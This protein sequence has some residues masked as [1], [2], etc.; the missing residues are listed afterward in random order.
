[1][2]TSQSKLEVVD[3]IT[4]S[5]TIARRVGLTI[6]DI[7]KIVDIFQDE[8]VTAIKE[9]KKVQINGFLVFQPQNVE[10]KTILSALDKKEY[11][12]PP[13]RTV[14]VKVGKLFRESI[15]DSY[16]PEETKEDDSNKKSTRTKKPK[17]AN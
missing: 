7:M 17:Q 3:K 4:L 6:M 1:M 15:K 2:I 12:L 16:R 8:V 5:K 14:S 11:T 9:N 10:G 13:K